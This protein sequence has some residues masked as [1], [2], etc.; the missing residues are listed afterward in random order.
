[1]SVTEV[2]AARSVF[3][4]QAV[5]PLHWSGHDGHAADLAAELMRCSELCRMAAEILTRD[6]Q[7]V[8]AAPT[9]IGTTTADHGTAPVKGLRWSV[10]PV[11][12]AG[13]SA[14]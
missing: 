5:D 12:P 3:S 4:T 10:E 14:A 2:H 8:P 11:S 6:G 1:M 7:D 13:R 9:L